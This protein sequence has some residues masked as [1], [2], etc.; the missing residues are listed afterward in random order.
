MKKIILVLLSFATAYSM[1][2]VVL[3]D[4][5]KNLAALNNP[6]YT[7]QYQLDSEKLIVNDKVFPISEQDGKPGIYTAFDVILTIFKLRFGH[8]EKM[9]NGTKDL[10]QEAIYQALKDKFLEELKLL[11]E[12]FYDL[13]KNDFYKVM[14]EAAYVNIFVKT[15]NLY[16]KAH[17]FY[18]FALRRL[19]MMNSRAPFGRYK[20]SDLSAENFFADCARRCHVTQFFYVAPWFERMRALEDEIVY[21]NIGRSDKN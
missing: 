1:Q 19:Q 11:N 9:F 13:V 3:T 6:P 7:L 12:A 17:M 8:L 16:E 14:N 15:L 18:L 20:M 5:Q 2:D 21:Q 10:K 4:F